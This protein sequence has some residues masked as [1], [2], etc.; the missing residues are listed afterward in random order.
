MACRPYFTDPHKMT[1]PTTQLSESLVYT[2]NRGIPSYAFDLLTINHRLKLI[3]MFLVSSYSPSKQPICEVALLS[4]LDGLGMLSEGNE[5]RLAIVFASPSSAAHPWPSIAKEELAACAD[6][7]GGEAALQRVPR[8]GSQAAAGSAQ[9]H[10]DVLRTLPRHSR[11]L[12]VS[13]HQHPFTN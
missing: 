2:A 8:A 11:L 7:D 4:A 9:R 10:Q 5:H 13:K 3:T 1:L 6:H 12:T